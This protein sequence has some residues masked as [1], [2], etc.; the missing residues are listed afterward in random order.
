M[1]KTFC[2]IPWNFQAVR[3]NGDIRICC[4]ANVTKNQ[5]VVRHPDGTSFNAGR[6]S[7]D[8][9]KNADM[10]KIVRKNMLAG[11]WSEECG[12]CKSE[13]EAG[14]QSRRLYELEHWKYSYE[15]AVRDTAPDGSITVRNQYY[16]LRFGNLCNLACRMCGPTDSHTWYEQWLGYHGGTSYEDTHGTVELKRNAKGR[17]E[18][19]DYDWHNSETFWEQ[20]EKNIPYIEHVYMAGGEPMMIERHYEFLQRCIDSG[21]AGNIM[22]EYNTNMTSLPPRVLKMWEHFKQIRLGCSIDGMGDVLEYQ[23]WPIKWKQAKA[24]LEKVD[25]LPK[26]IVAWI[27]F[28]VTAYNIFHLPEFMMWKLKESGFKKINSSPSKPVITHHVAHGPK[29]ANIRIL[30]KELKQDVHEHYNYYKNKLAKDDTISD[31]VKDKFNKILD[32]VTKYMD[33][34]DY[35]EKIPEFI[36]FTNYLDQERKQNILMVTPQYKEMFDENRTTGAQ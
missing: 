36:K 25:N 26:N 16:D 29:R 14:L 20:I 22:I 1:N 30:N 21:H 9:A 23:R 8:E 24:N 5:G 10:M 13:E 35:S 11:R 12:R 17:L 34:E 33:A 15:D 3:N 19:T 18:T 28:T 31:K 27:A 32:S 7:F 6:D 2:P 4:Q